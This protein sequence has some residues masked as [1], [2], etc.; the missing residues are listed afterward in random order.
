MRK[1]TQSGE[2]A[3]RLTALVYDFVRMKHKAEGVNIPDDYLFT[4]ETMGMV[5]D[6][7]D[8]LFDTLAEPNIQILQQMKMNPAT[9]MVLQNTTSLTG[10]LWYILGR[11]WWNEMVEYTD[12]ARKLPPAELKERINEIDKLQKMW[13]ARESKEPDIAEMFNEFKKFWKDKGDDTE[14]VPAGKK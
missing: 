7:F 9:G 4:H 10:V 8:E 11:G 2:E 6:A 1:Q 12:A 14:G 3:P 5:T 13:D